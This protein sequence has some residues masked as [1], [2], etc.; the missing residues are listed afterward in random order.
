MGSRGSGSTAAKVV[1]MGLAVT[2]AVT[3]CGESA[4]AEPRP[5]LAQ[6]RAKLAKLNDQMDQYVERYNLA[7][8]RWKEAKKKFDTVNAELTKE[9]ERVE[10]LRRD[11]AHMAAVAYQSGAAA[12]ALPNLIGAENPTD[13]LD[14]MASFTQLATSQALIVTSY[15]SVLDKLTRRRNDAKTLVTEAD[16]AR[17]DV[18]D[19]RTKIEKA[20][21]EQLKLL[22]RLGTYKA[23][24]PN[25]PGLKYNGPA[26]GNSL[27]V[28][29]F[30][31][32][33]I[34]KPYRWGGTGPGSWD[35][36]GLSQAAWA[37][38]GVSLPRTTTQQWAWGSSRRVSMDNLR[39][40]DLIFSRGLGHMGIYIGDGKMLHA[41]QTGD[42][43]KITPL[44]RY[45]NHR[46]LGGIRP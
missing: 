24:N 40:G 9:Q 27:A 21:R 20:V 29:R 10:V 6:A 35:C 25:S 44:S 36:S 39:P 23:G 41:P 22:R 2:L 14:Q 38:G 15:Q 37:K 12:F 4:V 17:K 7:T 33:Q 45:G 34:G 19:E 42:V 13:A 16:K 26:S 3:I 11:V 30:A 32:A 8:E 5:T 31:F 46:F 18:R 1:G 28:L 43:V